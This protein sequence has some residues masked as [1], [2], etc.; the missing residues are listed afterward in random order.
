MKTPQFVVVPFFSMSLILFV[1]LR[2]D[3]PSFGFYVPWYWYSHLQ[4]TSKN[5]FQSL[6]PSSTMSLWNDYDAWATNIGDAILAWAAPN[7]KNPPTAVSFPVF[8]FYV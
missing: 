3:R 7:L 4:T 1:E 8:F 5:R 6:F 2:T